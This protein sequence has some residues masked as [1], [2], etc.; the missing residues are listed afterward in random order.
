VNFSAIIMLLIG[1]LGLWGG[2][3]LSLWYYFQKDKQ[4]RQEGGS[5]GD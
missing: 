4:Y 5:Y 1:A 2:L 3:A